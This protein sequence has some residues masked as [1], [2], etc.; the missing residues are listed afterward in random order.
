MECYF[1]KKNVE[2][3]YKLKSSLHFTLLF[4]KK[5]VNNIIKIIKWF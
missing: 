5:Y 1:R 2:I 4:I 3:W